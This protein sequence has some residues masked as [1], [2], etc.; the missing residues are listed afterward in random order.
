MCEQKTRYYRE[1]YKKVSHRENLN[2]LKVFIND[3]I[4]QRQWHISEHGGKARDR[5]EP[6]E[7]P[8]A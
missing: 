7:L 5:E 2:I 4:Q 6:L 3:D 8:E 1:I